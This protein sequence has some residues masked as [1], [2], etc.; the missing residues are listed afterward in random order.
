MQWT[1]STDKAFSGMWFRLV[2]M[3]CKS[4]GSACIRK[5]ILWQIECWFRGLRMEVT[6]T[7]FCKTWT[8]ALTQRLLLNIMKLNVSE[9]YSVDWTPVGASSLHSRHNLYAHCRNSDRTSLRIKDYPAYGS[10]AGLRA[11]AQRLSRLACYCEHNKLI[12]L[13]EKKVTNFSV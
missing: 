2:T 1:V 8:E 10:P 6:A 9:Y 7:Y 13:C 11:A 12:F 5:Y 3:H 4:V